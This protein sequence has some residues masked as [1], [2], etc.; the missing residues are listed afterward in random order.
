MGGGHQKVTVS[1]DKIKDLEGV[2]PGIQEG[3]VW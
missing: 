2:K 3:N 1:K